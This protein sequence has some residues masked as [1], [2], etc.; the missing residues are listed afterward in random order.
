MA[1]DPLGTGGIPTPFLEGYR[2]AGG[3]LA[4]PRTPAAEDEAVRL[5]L[6]RLYLH[7]VMHVEQGPRGPAAPEH[8]AL[9]AQNLEAIVGRLA[10]RPVAV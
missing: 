8:R 1:A 6:Y 3:E 2:A 4:E 7:L 9:I 5:R 10:A